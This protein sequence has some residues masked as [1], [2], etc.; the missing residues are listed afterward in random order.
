MKP[1]NIE[2]ITDLFN[3]T[4]NLNHEKLY[5]VHPDMDEN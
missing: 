3:D 5:H 2:N 1:E 4:D